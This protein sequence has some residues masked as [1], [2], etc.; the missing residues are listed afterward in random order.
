MLKVKLESFD[1]LSDEEKES[2]S[3]NGCGKKYCN[4][5]RVIYHGI[6]ILLKSDAIEPEDM[7]FNRSLYWISEA[8]ETAYRLG[9][10]DS[11]RCCDGS[12]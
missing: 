8:I 6:T 3:E 1:D 10:E 7:T 12:C 9:V 2:A 4:Y 5:F 11:K